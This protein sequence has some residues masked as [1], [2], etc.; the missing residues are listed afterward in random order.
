V[1]IRDE[2]YAQL[3]KQLHR[4]G[5]RTS[6]TLMWHLMAY[7]LSCFRSGPCQVS[8]R[9]PSPPLYLTHRCDLWIGVLSVSCV[10]CCI[11]TVCGPAVS[12]SLHTHALNTGRR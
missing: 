9:P 8:C 4:N 1:D 3:C 10:N 2:I 11:D 7:C 6:E 5:S 12:S